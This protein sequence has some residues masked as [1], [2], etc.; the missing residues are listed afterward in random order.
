MQIQIQPGPVI[1]AHARLRAHIDLTALAM[2]CFSPSLRQ[3]ITVHSASFGQSVIS[4][5]HKHRER[6]P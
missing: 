4:I 1:S 3:G 2:F 6:M 5:P